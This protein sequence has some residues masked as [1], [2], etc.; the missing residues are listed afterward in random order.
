MTTVEHMKGTRTN[1]HHTTLISDY[2][3][4]SCSVLVISAIN[5]RN[6][7]KRHS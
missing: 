3:C 2:F 1:K 7:N 5:A 6:I 4:S